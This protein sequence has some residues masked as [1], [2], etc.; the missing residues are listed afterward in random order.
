MTRKTTGLGANEATL[1]AV[2]PQR[3]V[4]VLAVIVAAKK[5]KPHEG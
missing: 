5:S 2:A 1:L 3:S 4:T